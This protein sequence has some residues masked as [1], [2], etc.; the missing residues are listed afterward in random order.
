MKRFIVISTVI[1]GLVGVGLWAQNAIAPEHSWH[2]SMAA[3]LNLTDDQKAQAKTIFQQAHASSQAIQAQ[4]KDARQALANAAK[5]GASDAEIDRLA[6]AEGPLMA[7]VAA[8]HAKAFEKFYAILTPD[9]K[10]QVDA[11]PNGMMG[12]GMMGRSHGSKK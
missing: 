4:V 5:A 10:K 8:I 6:N 11:M 7:Q 9:Q 1:A 3:T 2:R 12:L